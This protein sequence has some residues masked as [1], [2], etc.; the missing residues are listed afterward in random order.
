VPHNPYLEDTPPLDD[1]PNAQNILKKGDYN[2]QVV[3]DMAGEIVEDL[4]SSDMNDNTFQ[5]L[6]L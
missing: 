6:N 1:M 2:T 3:N 5:A 4:F